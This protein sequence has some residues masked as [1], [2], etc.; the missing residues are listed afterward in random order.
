MLTPSSHNYNNMA[1][2]SLQECSGSSEITF[3]SNIG[4]STL[5]P[6]EQ[7]LDLKTGEVY[8]INWTSGMKAKEDPS[9]SS[10]SSSRTTNCSYSEDDESSY[11]ESGGLSSSESSSAVSSSRKENQSEQV[12]V[13]AGCKRC[14]MYFMVAKQVEECPKCNAQLLHFHRTDPIPS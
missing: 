14:L 4:T 10:S 5:L 1:A 11:E 6:W 7:T 8:Y 3:N 9:S 12:L 2:S 13:V